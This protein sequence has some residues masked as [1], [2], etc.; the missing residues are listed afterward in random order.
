MTG[1]GGESFVGYT[2]RHRH[3]S[4]FDS[5]VRIPDPKVDA[6]RLSS[7]ALE[8]NARPAISE[9]GGKVRQLEWLSTLEI[10]HCTQFVPAGSRFF[11]F[12]VGDYSRK[13]NGRTGRTRFRF[14]RH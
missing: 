6:I 4:V 2:L 9:I 3:D 10:Y 7:L 5:D 11:V 1:A 8:S 12:H 14:G 13:N